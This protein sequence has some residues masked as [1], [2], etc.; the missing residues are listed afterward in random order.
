MSVVMDNGNTVIFTVQATDF[1]GN[2]V[3]MITPPLTIDTTQPLITY[4]VCNVFLSMAQSE[5]SCTWDTT[6]DEESPLVVV[7]IGLGTEQLMDNLVEFRRM[8]ITEQTWAVLLEDEIFEAFNGTAVVSLMA[9]NKVSH[10]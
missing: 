2:E 10:I 5:L 9:D 3:T 8:V 6:L 1:A 7:I 4:M